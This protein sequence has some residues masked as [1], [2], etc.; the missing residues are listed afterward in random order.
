MAVSSALA[1]GLGAVRMKIVAVDLGAS[2][3]GSLGIL[4]AAVSTLATT[5]GCGLGVSAIGAIAV[6]LDSGDRAGSARE[7]LRRGTWVL[8]PTAGLVSCAAW[9]WW[10]DDF[11]GEPLGFLAPWLG[12]AVFATILT[13]RYSALLSGFGKVR[14]LSA[15]NVVGAA[16]ATLV[17]AASIPSSDRTML[18]AAVAAPPVALAA[19]TA[20]ASRVFA[21]TPG[22]RGGTWRPELR[23]MIKLG[24]TVSSS[25]IMVSASQLFATSWVTRTLGIDSAGLFQ[26][27]WSIAN[28]YLVFLLSALT[29]EYLPR[30]S[31]LRLDPL[32]TSEAAREQVR[33]LILLAAPIIAW[34]LVVAPWLL[35]LLYTR[36]FAQAAGLLRVQL[37]GDVF[38]VL[39]WTLA[40]ILLARESKTRYFAGE[41]SWNLTFVGL[42]ALLA[43]HGLEFVG[44]AY[45]AAYVVY[46]LI[47]V[48]QTR[49]RLDADT[50]RLM[51]VAL[52]GLFAVYALTLWPEGARWGPPVGAVLISGW[53]LWK[54]RRSAAW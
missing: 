35:Q 29:A 20:L 26:A 15:A 10:G 5:F 46:L 36:D 4:M 8:A 23:S 53:A 24:V 42:V 25:V 52:S 21:R 47:T 45:A 32:A 43:R 34:L 41:L 6:G 48:A 28:L 9:F 12:V 27:S 19:V 44:V 33:L 3:I 54:L 50:R 40:F 16:L 18:A 17:V 7:A 31:K 11:T 30:L 49:F 39:G 1:L 14:E 38:K 13:A 2:G 37:L 22:G 51:L